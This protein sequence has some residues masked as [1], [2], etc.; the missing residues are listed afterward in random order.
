MEQSHEIEME[1]L[2]QEELSRKGALTPEQLMA[3]AAS[4]NMNS[5]AASKF[6][7]SFSAGRNAEQMQQAN[8]ARIA[9]AHRHEDQMMEIIRQMAQMNSN[10]ATG[11]MQQNQAQ[12]TEQARQMERQE[13]RIDHI[14]DSALEYATRNNKISNSQPEQRPVQTSAQAVERFCPKCGTAVARNI[15]FCHHCGADL[16]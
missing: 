13:A 1:R 14:T 3:I 9:D 7:E 2:H 6:A 15:R 4:E 5:D 10:M 12:R 11:M 8:D 16:N